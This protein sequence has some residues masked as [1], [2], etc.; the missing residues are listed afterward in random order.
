MIPFVRRSNG[1]NYIRVVNGTP[2]VYT[3]ASGNVPVYQYTVCQTG[4]ISNDYVI[5]FIDDAHPFYVVGTGNV[6]SLW[7]PD[8]CYYYENIDPNFPPCASILFDVDTPFVARGTYNGQSITEDPFFV[9]PTGVNAA[10]IADPT[11]YSG[12]SLPMPELNV[13]QIARPS[14]GIE[15]DGIS[16]ASGTISQ[17]DFYE[18]IKSGIALVWGADFW[19][20]MSASSNKL[21]IIRETGVS[22]GSG[23]IQSGVDL[24]KSDLSASGINYIEHFPSCGDNERYLGWIT[25]C[26][27]YTG[28]NVSCTGL[29][30]I[31]NI[32]ENNIQGSGTDSTNK[33]VTAT[34]EGHSTDESASPSYYLE[35]AKVFDS[36][37]T[38]YEGIW[39]EY[40]N[41]FVADYKEYDGSLNVTYE[42]GAYFYYDNGIPKMDINAL[43]RVPPNSNANSLSWTCVVPLD[44]YGIPSGILEP[45]AINDALSVLTLT[46]CTPRFPNIVFTSHVPNDWATIPCGTGCLNIN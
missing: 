16:I 7:G 25:D 4:V 40:V 32:T 1:I 23:V 19:N 41:N 18:D 14:G 36:N 29:F 34:F 5:T 21:W 2:Y 44:K 6:G 3:G 30:S 31:P 28:Q 27:S 8:L 24:F 11:N 9:Y 46:S 20:R 22:L 26:V 39:N 45:E 37:T 15:S 10:A 35:I 43:C 42:Y 12:C 13:V 38:Y 17:F 33:L